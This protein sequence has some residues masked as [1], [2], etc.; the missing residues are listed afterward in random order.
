MSE[1]IIKDFNTVLPPKRIAK[2]ADEEIDVSLIPSRV[3][4]ELAIFR[5][6]I[7]KGKIKSLEE[8]YRKS[9]EIVAKICQVKNPKIT[10]EWL[11]E[12]TNYEQLN[13]FIDFVFE[14]IN[15]LGKGKSKKKVGR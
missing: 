10:P 6:S 12:N 2:L 3:T 11:I 8:Q 15:R 1:P 4:L 13:E 5:D 14:P 9:V 7:F